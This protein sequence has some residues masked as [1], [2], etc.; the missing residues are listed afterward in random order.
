MVTFLRTAKCV[1]GLFA[2]RKPTDADRLIV[3]MRPFN[4]LCIEPPD[5]EM[6]SPE[7]LARLIVPPG[8]TIYFAKADLEG[9]FH[10]CKVP[11]WFW[12]YFALPAVQAGDLQLPDFQPNE[13][14][15]PA[16]TTLPMGFSHSVAILQAINCRLLDSTE[17]ARISPTSD[18][19]LD[20]ARVL[21]WVDDS[22][23]IATTPSSCDVVL[24]Q[25][26]ARVQPSGLH[27]AHDK[28]VRPNANGVDGLGF[29]L[30]GTSCTI[31]PAYGPLVDLIL[32]TE[33]VLRSQSISGEMLHHIIGKWVW[34]ALIVRGA[35]SFLDQ[36][37]RFIAIAG[38][39]VFTIW[40]AV[41]IE[42]A[43][44]LAFAPL[45]SVS[46]NA[47]FLPRVVAS[48]AS[49]IGLGIVASSLSQ[50]DATM[51]GSLP[52]HPFTPD[53]F[54]AAFKSL[55]L[56]FCDYSWSVIVSVHWRNQEHINVL[57]ARA[58]LC[59]IKWLC[60]LKSIPGS[61]VNIFLDS[62]V[63]YAAASKGRSSSRK[64]NTVLRKIAVW[65]F[66]ARLQLFL[67][68]IPTDLNPAD[69]PSRFPRH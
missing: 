15:F 52:H 24:T 60:S 32:L 33:S 9:A 27:I 6:P 36:V 59:A 50:H 13:Y 2:V 69:Y 66:V 65:C 42:L 62:S 29:H 5:P 68:W 14:V 57:G 31:L 64:L 34:A 58:L 1:N 11:A 12:P 47:S 63:V 45:F 41:R 10:T 17:A 38:S 22:I 49:M 53:D 28:T 67:H 30:H 44:L 61:R 56:Q 51:M 39:R 16:F 46:L 26:I 40:P 35:L 3:D 55:N 21:P 43:L 37:Y 23:F 8:A 7:L 4:E 19:R 18:L 20:R 54:V 25:Y 48:D